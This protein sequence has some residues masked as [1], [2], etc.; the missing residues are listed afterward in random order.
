MSFEQSDSSPVKDAIPSVFAAVRALFASLPVTRETTPVVLAV[1][2]GPDS[3]CMADAVLSLVTELSIVPVIGH[4]NHG[5]R[6][7]AA[8]DDAD[9]VRGFAEAHHTKYHIETRDVKALAAQKHLSVETAARIA[10]YT[11]LS[12]VAQKEGASYIALAHNADDQV[13]TILQRFIRGTGVNG[14]QGM[15]PISSLLTDDETE[16]LG[17]LLLR[18]LLGIRRVVIEAYC[19]ERGLSPRHDLT[20]DEVHHQR[21]R[22]RHELLPLLEQYNPGIRKVLLRLAETAATDMEIV[23]WATDETLVRL[24]RADGERT[25]YDRKAWCQL[26]VGMQRA[27]LRRALLN[28]HGNL[29]H[30][31]Y[32]GIEEARDVLNSNAAQA[33]IAILAGVRIIVTRNSFWFS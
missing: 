26:P 19:L 18:P 3:L 28:Y 22:V 7:R 4:L 1:S 16:E 31:K 29:T 15:K 11:F 9:F 27:T 6:G 23:D 33:E 5:L 10:R 8:D 30:V 2:G 12:S 32:T 13:E 20:N 14:L 24:Q 25:T 21:N 17:L